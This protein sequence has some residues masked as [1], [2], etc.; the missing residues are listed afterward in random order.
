MII[1]QSGFGKF[2]LPIDEKANAFTEGHWLVSGRF[3][4]YSEVA[5]FP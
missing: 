2:I 4:G 3:V 1:C 5:G